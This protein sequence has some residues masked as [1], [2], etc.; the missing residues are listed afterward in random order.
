[1]PEEPCLLDYARFHGLAANHRAVDL[2][3]LLPCGG[4]VPDLS[5]PADAAMFAAR[6]DVDYREKLQPSQRAFALLASIL[7][8]P[9]KPRW[10]EHLPDPHHGRKLKQEVPLPRTDNELDLRDFQHRV[11]LPGLRNSGLAPAQVDVKKH[12][13]LT[14]PASYDYL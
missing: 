2:L 11:Q 3:K 7:R 8:P 5:D 9:P 4:V 10:E 1:M 14:W 6:D 12:E 13:G